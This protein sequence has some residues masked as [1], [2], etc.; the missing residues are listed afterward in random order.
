MGMYT[1]IVVGVSL[2]PKAPERVV[3]ALK[4]MAGLEPD[5]PDGFPLSGERSAWMLRGGSYYFPITSGHVSMR[6]DEIKKAWELQARSNIKNYSGEIEE[7]FKWIA[8]YIE[9]QGDWTIMGYS[10]YE[11]DEQDTAHYAGRNGEHAT[12]QVPLPE[13]SR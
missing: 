6:F 1:E 2:N 3:S 10:R 7:F 11:E 12:V 13:A 4:F 8:P 9:T 5:E